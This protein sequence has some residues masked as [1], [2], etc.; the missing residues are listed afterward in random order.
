L[1]TSAMF[2]PACWRPVKKS[3]MQAMEGHAR[4]ILHLR[5]HGRG[6]RV[7]LIFAHACGSIGGEP[8]AAGVTTQRFQRIPRGRHRCL[9]HDAPPPLR[10]FLFVDVAPAALRA[11]VALVELR[12][13]ALHLAGA[14]EG[15]RTVAAMAGGLRRLPAVGFRR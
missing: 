6:R 1:S 14:G 12:V 2:S 10:L 3:A 7:I 5:D 8:L 9:A 4:A 11:T 15:F 13:C